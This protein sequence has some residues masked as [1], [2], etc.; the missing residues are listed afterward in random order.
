MSETAQ[1]MLS[2]EEIRDYLLN[3]PD[4]FLEQQDLF[5]EINF[6]HETSGA[7]SLIERQ[8]QVLR[9]SQKESQTQV[10]ELTSTATANHELLKKMQLLTLELIGAG[11]TATLINSL[12]GLMRGQFE[13]DKTQLLMP[14]QFSDSGMPLTLF[15]TEDTLAQMQADIFNLDIYVGRV[16]AKL[17]DYFSQDSLE[18]I[19]S[20][21]LLKLQIAERCGYLLM[22]SSD[23]SRFQSDMAT[24][25]IDFVANVLSMLLKQRLGNPIE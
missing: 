13:L 25:F 24:D 2:S 16:P 18:N 21:A 22:G 1:K 8:V 20:I 10:A 11:D 14:E 4:F 3:N 9:E 5:T 23:E 19:G 7:V 17:G 6:P 12:D 15:L